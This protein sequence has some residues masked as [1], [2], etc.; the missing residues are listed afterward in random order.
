M[1]WIER[2]LRAISLKPRKR[3]RVQQI[4]AAVLYNPP[5]SGLHESIGQ[6]TI[7]RQ[8]FPLATH[9]IVL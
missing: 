2:I 4:P 8:R 7:C 9:M 1:T 5:N 6:A 3:W